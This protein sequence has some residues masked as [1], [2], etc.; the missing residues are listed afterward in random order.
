MRA[1]QCQD[2]QRG[3]SRHEGDWAVIYFTFNKKPWAGSRD[4][5]EHSR[6]ELECPVIFHSPMGIVCSPA[7]P[8]Q[9]VWG[10]SVAQGLYD[11]LSLQ[12]STTSLRPCREPQEGTRNV[13][14]GSTDLVS[15]G[16][17]FL[18]RNPLW[19]SLERNEAPCMCQK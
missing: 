1:L 10:H 5:P 12:S 9:P 13:C 15:R 2:K 6:R 17:I 3:H 11:R 16:K 19:M 7:S 18:G 8:A 14:P 4:N